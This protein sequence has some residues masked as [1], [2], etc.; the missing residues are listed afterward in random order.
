MGE[1]RQQLIGLMP[2]DSQTPLTAGAH[3]YAEDASASAA[4]GQGYVTS[5]AYSPT[6]GSW[7]GLAF[8]TNGRARHGETIRLDDGLRGEK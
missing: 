2:V 6:L 5:V 3:L 7:L 8:L 4:N 1:D